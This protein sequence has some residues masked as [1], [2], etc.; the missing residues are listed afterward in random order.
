MIKKLHA[1]VGYEEVVGGFQRNTQVKGMGKDIAEA[2][3]SQLK[4]RK[5]FKH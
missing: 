5:D 1:I 4:G 3:I 2:K